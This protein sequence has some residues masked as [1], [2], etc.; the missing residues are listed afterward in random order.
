MYARNRAADDFCGAKSQLPLPFFFAV[1]V[2]SD[3]RIEFQ[4]IEIADHL[5]VKL[6]IKLRTLRVGKAANPLQLLVMPRL[7][8]LYRL[9]FLLHRKFLV[10]W[11]LLLDLPL[12]FPL[13]YP[14]HHLALKL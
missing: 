2:P 1:S 7:L 3:V 5:L 12:S 14:L 13:A 9:R 6:L 8:E 11:F 4:H 10:S